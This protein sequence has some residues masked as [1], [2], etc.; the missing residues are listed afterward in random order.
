[1]GA[2]AP[3]TRPGTPPSSQD[4]SCSSLD[5]G[6]KVHTLNH[7]STKDHKPNRSLD[8]VQKDWRSRAASRHQDQKEHNQ[9]ACGKISGRC[10][11]LPIRTAGKIPEEQQP[12]RTLPSASP[13]SSMLV[14]SPSRQEG[15][16]Q[17]PL[18]PAG[19]SAHLKVPQLTC[20][21]PAYFYSRSPQLHFW[22]SCS[23]KTNLLKSY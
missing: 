2:E 13:G 18:A 22:Y 8:P 6:N 23:C 12:S 21:A 14:I 5:K 1:M 15:L 20:I 9:E 17:S 3:Q 4:P 19:S 11:A 16:Q 7:Q 10:E